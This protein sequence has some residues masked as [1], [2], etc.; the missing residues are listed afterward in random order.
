M[1]LCLVQVAFHDR[2]TFIGY[3]FTASFCAGKLI[4]SVD[5][6]FNDFLVRFLSLA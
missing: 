2:K 1:L 5:N 6:D 3:L 4:I